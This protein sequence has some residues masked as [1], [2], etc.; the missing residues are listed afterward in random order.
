MKANFKR[1]LALLLIPLLAVGFLSGCGKKKAPAEPEGLPAQAEI[2]DVV[3]VRITRENL[4]DYFEYKE[5]PTEVKGENNGE[6]SNVQVAY[7]LALR[8]GWTAA[9]DPKR[10]DTLRVDFTADQVV[11]AGRF[12]VD[13]Q[14]LQWSGTPSSTERR[15]ISEKLVFWPK[16]DRTS[17]WTF[18][19]FS[20]S[21]ILYLEN[22]TVTSASGTV[23]LK[24]TG[25]TE[26][27]EN[28]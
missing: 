26:Q 17:V 8:E 24:S 7:G 15:Q 14:T 11:N 27:T 10:K 28:S 16:G 2:D 23:Y 6:I 9:N 1:T 4:F 5:F 13:F 19:N 12:T 3:E 25:L 20:D 22:F 18:G 21:Y